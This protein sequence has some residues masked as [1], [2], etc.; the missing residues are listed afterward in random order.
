MTDMNPI[1]KNSTYNTRA[2]LLSK[3]YKGFYVPMNCYG[4]GP[5]GKK[6]VA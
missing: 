6:R 2:R 1:D 4:G 3:E 5:M